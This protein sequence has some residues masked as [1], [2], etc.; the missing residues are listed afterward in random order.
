MVKKL[1]LQRGWSQEQLAELVG[2]SVR[3]IQ[4]IERGLTPGLETA[5]ALASVFEVELSTF[6]PEEK[7]MNQEQ[8]QHQHVEANLKDDE[9][10]AMAYVK[11]LKEFY[12]HLLVY[13]VFFVVYGGLAVF[14]LMGD[15]NIIL[16]GLAGW[17]VGV[18]IHGL[19]AFEKLSL[20]GLGARWEKK[21]IEKRLGRKL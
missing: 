20:M 12:D 14:K 11:G 19:V 10:E 4:R 7:T 2:V 9:K 15:M 18:V 13:S 16:F 17:G 6:M 8:A 21:A 1:R 5:K 3:T